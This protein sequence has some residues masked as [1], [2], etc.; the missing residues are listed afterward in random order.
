MEAFRLKQLTKLEDMMKR[1]RR[2]GWACLCSHVRDRNRQELLKEEKETE[3][4]RIKDAFGI[5]DGAVEGHAF[6]FESERERQERL[7]RLAEEE[8]LDKRKRL[9]NR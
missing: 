5:K 4:R 3:M 2:G 8:R 1:Y 9:G 6:K 7:A